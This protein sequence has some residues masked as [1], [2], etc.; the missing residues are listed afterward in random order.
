MRSW[1]RA[2]LMVAVVTVVACGARAHVH[3][4]D[5]E[6]EAE[7]QSALR[8]NVRAKMGGEPERADASGVPFP[9]PS[10]WVVPQQSLP[11]VSYD[12][13]TNT[14]LGQDDQTVWEITGAANG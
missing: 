1:T 2:V 11:A 6:A 13:T 9:V 3:A 8:A 4:A 14:V 12:P 10:Y 7:A 5:A